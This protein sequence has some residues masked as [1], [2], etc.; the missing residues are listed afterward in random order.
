MGDFLMYVM[1]ELNYINI[2]IDQHRNCKPRGRGAVFKTR[3]RNKQYFVKQFEKDGK[4]HRTYLGKGDS[5]KVKEEKRNQ[6]EC[7]LYDALC[8]N[9][10]ILESVIQNFKTYSFEALSSR[11]SPC[12][13]EVS[14]GFQVDRRLDQLFAWAKEDYKKNTNPFPD[15]IILAKDRTRVRSKDECIWYNCLLDAGLPFRY[16]SVMEFDDPWNPGGIRFKSP[17]FAINTPSGVMVLIEHAGL[18]MK[19]QY[20]EDM[21][22]KI[23]LYLYNGYVLGDNFFI[24]SED[25]FGGINSYAIKRQVAEIKSR[26]FTC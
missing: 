26:F 15:K 23:Q 20:L 6:L 4:V 22:E 17:D 16:D 13:A 10:Q 5:T 18:L 11:I 19:K 9:K 1:A 3:S 14:C 8:Q 12:L 2:L 24:I 25:R 7:V 21:K